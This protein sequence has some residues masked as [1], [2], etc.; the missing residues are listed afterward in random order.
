MILG[1]R[2]PMRRMALWMAFGFTFL[3]QA[4]FAT[5]GAMKEV[6]AADFQ[7]AFNAATRL[8]DLGAGATLR[9]R[10]SSLSHR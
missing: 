2:G 6:R 4:S 10:R 5:G 1:P 3:E 8:A 9:F 7:T